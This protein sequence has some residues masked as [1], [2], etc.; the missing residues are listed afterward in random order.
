[1]EAYTAIEHHELVVEKFGRWPNFHDGEVHRVV[2]DRLRRRPNG[3]YY[4]SV[5]L[6]IRGWLITS[7]VDS[8]GHY[9]LKHD[10]VVHFLFEE[11][12]ELELYD[13]NQQ[14][15]ISSLKIGKADDGLILELAPCYGLSGS[16]KARR[17]S[18]VAVMPYVEPAP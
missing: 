16:F 8:E 15:V 18:V 14:N 2:L 17:G 9:K 5:E 4:A 3:R 6:Q 13:L 7:E 11:V 1:M 12:T 10:S